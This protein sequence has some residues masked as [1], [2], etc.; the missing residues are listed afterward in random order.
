MLQTENTIEPNFDCIE[1]G[2]KSCRG[3]VKQFFRGEL[4]YASNLS[5]ENRRGLDAVL[6]NLMR[7]IDMLELESVSGLALD[8]WHEIRD[9]LSDAFS[10]KYHSVE[11][12]ALVDTARRYDIPKQFLFD[13]LRGADIW[14]RQREFQSWEDLEAFLSN[15]GGSIMASIVPLLEPTSE[16]WH[17][18]AFEAG[19][20]IMLTRIMANCVYDIK[21]NRIFFA[22]DDIENCE[23]DI[24]RIKL[25]RETKSFRH[26]IRLYAA[27]AEKLLIDGSQLVSMVDF[28]GKRSL[29]SLLAY[30][31]QMLTKM[32][33]QPELALSDRG[34]FTLAEQ[35]GFKSK[36]LM[37]LK[38]H[39]PFLPDETVTH[40]H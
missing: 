33:I 5:S 1:R 25:R 4:W 14:I 9:E 32:K 30:H 38:F 18:P 40:H 2:Y 6:F 26:L 7:T 28:D 34:I 36:H 31:W 8:V 29:T 23:V 35:L 22:K 20:A 19:K 10:D 3:A 24:P 21:A 27:R 15:V 17:I 12:T 16:D 11:L 39:L 37:G 13:P